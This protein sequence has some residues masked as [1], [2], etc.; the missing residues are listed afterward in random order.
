MF[1]TV[2]PF[3]EVDVDTLV[4]MSL[5]FFLFF[6][7][8]SRI[9]VFKQPPFSY[10]KFLNYSISSEVLKYESLILF[11]IVRQYIGLPQRELHSVS[12]FK[13]FELSS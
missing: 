7:F 5:S 10:S 11:V 4:L 9:A 12:I 6:D 1:G 2:L 3:V 13:M 8:L